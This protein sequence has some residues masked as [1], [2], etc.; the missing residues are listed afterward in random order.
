MIRVAEQAGIVEGADAPGRDDVFGD[1][2][3]GL[4][5]AAAGRLPA[6]GLLATAVPF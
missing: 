4:E 3:V 5:R 6:E 2:V 1:P